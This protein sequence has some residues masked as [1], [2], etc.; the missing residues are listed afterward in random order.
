[1]LW[2]L[3]IGNIWLL[4]MLYIFLLDMK[5]TTSSFVSHTLNVITT[6]VP[7]FAL[8]N[9]LLLTHMYVG[10]FIETSIASAALGMGGGLMLGSLYDRDGAVVGISNGFLAGI[11]APIL[12]EISG[13]SSL[14]LFFSQF[15]FFMVLFYFRFRAQKQQGPDPI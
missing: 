9:G 4:V 12:G 15:I 1:M 3:F 5:D 14:I 8:C 10:V 6:P 13:R 11:M 2:I 7:L